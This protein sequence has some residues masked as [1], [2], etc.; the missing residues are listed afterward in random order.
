MVTTHKPMTWG[1]YENPP[2]DVPECGFVGELCPPEVRGKF[3]A[4]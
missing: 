3:Y 4:F 2:Q 1:I